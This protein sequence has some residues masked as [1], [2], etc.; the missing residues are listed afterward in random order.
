[1]KT[2]KERERQMEMKREMYERKKR[3][4]AL[5]QEPRERKKRQNKDIGKERE[6]N[7]RPKKKSDM[8]FEALCVTEWSTC[9]RR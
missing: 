9:E 8:K 7:R 2:A 1:M 3:E 5:G 6:K 4:G